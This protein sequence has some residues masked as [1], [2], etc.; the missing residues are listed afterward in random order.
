MSRDLIVRLIAIA[1]TLG[2]PACAEWD[3]RDEDEHEEED[4][5]EREGG[6]TTSDP[7]CATGTRWTGGESESP[8]MLPGETCIGCHRE[9]DDGPRGAAGTVYLTLDEPDHCY[10]MPALTVQITDANGIT[11]RTT[12]SPSGNFYFEEQIAT[13]F[14]AK[15]IDRDGGESVMLTAQTETDCNSCHTAEGLNLAPGRIIAP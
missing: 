15:V 4:D 6:S 12:T 2:N 14:T 10:G 13:P 7:S 1:V 5:E 8:N 3:D 11:H 9:E